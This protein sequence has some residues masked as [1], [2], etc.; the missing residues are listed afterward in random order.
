[1][2]VAL[3][4]LRDTLNLGNTIGTEWR[5]W[6]LLVKMPRWAPVFVGHVDSRCWY[7][8]AACIARYKQQNHVAREGIM[9]LHGKNQLHRGIS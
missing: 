3:A 6:E 7:P 8:G 1:M 9:Q 2:C 4:Q 5:R